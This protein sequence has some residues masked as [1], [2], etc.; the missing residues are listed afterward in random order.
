[1]AVA[2]SK[3]QNEIQ[4]MALVELAYEVLKQSK[5][6]MYFRD[7]MK[8]I[9]DLRGMTED[10]A[11]AVIA[12]VYTE[13][14]ID[15]RFLC[16]GQNV[17]GLKRW[18]PADRTQE[19]SLTSKRFVRKSGDAFSDDDEDGLDDTDELEIDSDDDE[20]SPLLDDDSESDDDDY[21]DDDS[22]SDEDFSDDDDGE[23]SDDEDNDDDDEEEDESE[24]EDESL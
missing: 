3:S 6:P 24:D 19:K 11:M 9:Q 12:R 1:M 2:L 5:D 16:L 7:L 8:E 22:E 20:L 4:N 23:F 18:Y 10:E 15:G 17:W 13:L 14:N 21:A